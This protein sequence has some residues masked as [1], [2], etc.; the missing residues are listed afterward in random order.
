MTKRWR[1]LATVILS[2]VA[3]DANGPRQSAVVTDSSGIQITELQQPLLASGELWSIAS[4]PLLDI[5]VRE[6]EPAYELHRVVGAR[7]LSNGSI[8]V[9][10]SGTQQ[11]KLF[12]AQG[13]YIR[14]MGRAGKGPG[15]FESMSWVQLL[16][17]DTLLITDADL[18]RVSAYTPDGTLRWTTNLQG[19]GY[20]WPGDSRLPDGTFV[21]VTETG[22]V[23][24]RIRTG[25]VKSGQTDR[26][27]AVVV[28]FTA[29]G[30]LVDT[31]GRFPGYEEAILENQGRFSTTYPPW[32]RLITHAL[33]KDRMYVGSQENSEIK[34]YLLDGT[35]TTIIRWPADDLAINSA[36]LDRF[37]A[38]L[39][40][41]AP[42]D[43][44]THQAIVTRTKS[45]P[46]PPSKPA[47]GR[48]IIDGA[49]L[50]WISEAYVPIA[51]PKHWT[52]VE[53]G[54][55]VRGQVDL[56]SR[57]DVYEIGIDYVLGRWTDED[58]VQHVRVHQLRRG[59]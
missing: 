9:A 51:A 57:F 28:R 3:C 48:L 32:G 53:P 13:Q 14:S 20:A 23:W 55:G 40:D 50:L 43:S 12:D 35:L 54:V 10:N 15:E 11:L 56:P 33:A 18:R 17:S 34:A 5:G 39:F 37:N 58:G 49:G 38:V 8:V 6:G 59:P 24:Q 25:E 7:R 45:L 41:L 42:D 30:A 21:L 36:D 22:D 1:I 4:E 19:T 44:A 29:S 26:N 27:T 47:Y 2:L 16:P 31:L 52:V 46:V